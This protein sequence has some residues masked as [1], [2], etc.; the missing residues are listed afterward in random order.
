MHKIHDMD[1]KSNQKKDFAFVFDFR[2]HLQGQTAPFK[3]L[4]V[5]LETAK[6]DGDFPALDMSVRS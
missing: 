2:L 3:R 1:M 4:S 5:A 6:I